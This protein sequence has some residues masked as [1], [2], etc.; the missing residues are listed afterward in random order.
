VL[1][2][3]VDNKNSVLVIEHNL[4]VIKTAD[5]LV[6]MGPEGGDAGGEVVAAGTPEEVAQCRRNHTGA[7]LKEI[8]EEGSRG[9]KARSG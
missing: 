9:S 3:L 1:N 8:F 5:W 6:D 2:R 4:D 7:F